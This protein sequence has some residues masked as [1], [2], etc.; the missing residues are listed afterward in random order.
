MSFYINNWENAKVWSAYTFQKETFPA[1]VE[2]DCSAQNC[3][4]P[5][6][7]TLLTKKKIFFY[8]CVDA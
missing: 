7:S 3:R 6:N 8:L 4:Y 5:L 2:Y 1:I